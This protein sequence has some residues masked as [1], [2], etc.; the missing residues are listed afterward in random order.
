M[1]KTINGVNISV[2]CQA[3]E[4]TEDSAIPEAYRLSQNSPNPFNSETE[5]GYQL[6]ET[7]PVTLTIYNLI[8]QRICVLVDE[9][10]PAGYHFVGWDGKDDSGSL[11]TSG[12][13]LY[14]LQAG[15]FLQTRKMVLMR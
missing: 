11:L 6:P 8:G 12:M 9:R 1:F 5:I 10:K 4:L 15:D 2:N 3:D 14:V 13:Y 7:G